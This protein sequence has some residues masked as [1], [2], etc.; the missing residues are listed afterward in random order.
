MTRLVLMCGLPGAGKTTRA[1]PLATRPA[2]VRFTPDE[3]LADLGL[4]ATTNRSA[5][6]WRRSSGGTPRICCGTGK[7]AV[8]HGQRRRY[9]CVVACRGSRTRWAR[10]PEPPGEKVLKYGSTPP[11]SPGM[12]IADIGTAE[13]DWPH[14]LQWAIEGCGVRAVY[15]PIVDLDRRTIAG[16]EALVRFV[17]YPVRQPEPWLAMAGEHGCDAELQAAALRESLAARDGLPPG[18]FLT[19]NI[20]PSALRATAVRRLWAGQGD[21]DGLV[22]E[23]TAHP[24]SDRDADLRRLRAAGALVAIDYTGPNTPST[25]KPDM[26]KLDRTQFGDA[27]DACALA[28]AVDAELIAE[29]VETEAELAALVDLGVAYAQGYHLGRPGR[30]W[31]GLT[32]SAERQLLLHHG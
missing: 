30:P 31:V 9:V 12:T 16:Y 22:I 20:H 10:P 11:T 2:A 7:P 26:I 24:A 6:A 28:E 27:A 1:R 29:G 15:Q 3:W 17:G 13:L 32:E 8:V 14:M 23:L 5:T 25:L 4:D 18:C 19:V 21:L